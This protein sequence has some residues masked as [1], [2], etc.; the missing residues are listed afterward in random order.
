MEDLAMLRKFLPI[1]VLLC[2]CIAGAKDLSKTLQARY[3]VL[4]QAIIKRDA[5]AAEKWVALYCTPKFLYISK[6]KHRWDRN[7]FKQGLLDQMKLT[8]KVEHSTIKL[9]KPKIGGNKLTV[10]FMNDFRA[11][12]SYDGRD[13]TLIDNTE[14]EDV[15]IKVGADW[16]L[17]SVRQ[18]KANT[19]MF[20]QKS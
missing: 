15:W 6:D 10:L 4:N 20:H 3:S 5:K 18:T 8:K 1:C 16:K 9:G 7:G 19:Q 12:L 14:T 11:V 13:L 2:S 17:S